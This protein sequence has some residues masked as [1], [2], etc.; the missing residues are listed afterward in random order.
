MASSAPSPVPFGMSESLDSGSITE[1]LAK[2]EAFKILDNQKKD[3]FDVS[4]Q[5]WWFTKP[6]TKSCSMP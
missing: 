2:Y 3:F 5:T 6:G 1:L 4:D